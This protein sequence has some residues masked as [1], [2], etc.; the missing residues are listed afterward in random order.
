M[1]FSILININI[2]ILDGVYI[3]YVVVTGINIVV[4]NHISLLFRERLRS[5]KPPLRLKPAAEN[6]RPRK[7]LNISKR[8]PSDFC[9]FLFVSPF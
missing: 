3:V 2:Y 7:I 5:T 9:V 8:P 4:M 1:T 6:R